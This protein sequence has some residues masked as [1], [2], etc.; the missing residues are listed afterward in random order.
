MYTVYP[1]YFPAP[2]SSIVPNAP[3]RVLIVVPETV[4]LPAGTIVNV[5]RSPTLIASGAPTV[6][7]TNLIL[8]AF[9]YALSPVRFSTDRC[10]DQSG[11]FGNLRETIRIGKID[12]KGVCPL[13]LGMPLPL[14]VTMP[15]PTSR[16]ARAEQGRI[17]FS[18]FARDLIADDTVVREV[19][20]N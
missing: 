14:V 8:F 12:T 17:H 3:V 20:L 2:T 6:L 18:K 4:A 9:I 7:N 19:R 16:A 10:I 13:N 5:V 11:T 1:A 15:A